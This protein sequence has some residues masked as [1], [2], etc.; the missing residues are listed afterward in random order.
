MSLFDIKKL[1][2]KDGADHAVYSMDYQQ[3]VDV[4][5]NYNAREGR[6]TAEVSYMTQ[7]FKKSNCSFTCQ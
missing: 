5:I 6:S 3:V 7:T 4:S 1:F 2:F